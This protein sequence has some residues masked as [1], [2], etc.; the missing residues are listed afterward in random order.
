MEAL[1]LD[2]RQNSGGFLNEAIEVA[3]KFVEGGRKLVYTVGRIDG[4]SEEYYSTGRATHTRFPMIVLVDRGS[5]S[6]SEIV[7]GAVQDWDRGLVIGEPTFGKGLVQRQF[8][9]KN[10]GALLVTVA[11]YYTPS[12]RLIQRDYSDREDYFR[13]HRGDAGAEEDSTDLTDQPVYHTAGGRR[14]YGGG[15]ITPDV[16]VH[17]EGERSELQDKIESDRTYFEF[18]NNYIGRNH[19]TWPDGFDSFAAEFLVS[20]EMLREFRDYLQEKEIEVSFDSLRAEYIE[21][22][23]GIRRE[24]ARNLWGE[25][26]WRQIVIEADPVIPEALA[27]LPQAEM[28]ARGEI[29]PQE[30]GLREIT[31]F[32]GTSQDGRVQAD[33]PADS[34]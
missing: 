14:V 29:P 27:L 33:I 7:S 28:M 8:P 18:A 6:A 16:V 5:A 21:V 22:A 17:I 26:E 32:I 1:I 25:N 11:R 9:L 2:L 31:V 3:D 24:M 10:N 23:R 15:G 30:P 20:D 13:A 4:S 19:F 12:G 34:P